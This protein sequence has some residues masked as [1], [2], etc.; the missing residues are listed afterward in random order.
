MAEGKFLVADVISKLKN[1]HATVVN[2]F[3]TK[4]MER[5]KTLKKKK[6][7]LNTTMTIN[8]EIIG[9]FT[10]INRYNNVKWIPAESSTQAQVSP[11]KSS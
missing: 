2:K 6:Q 10:A 8:Y 3:E 1:P 9:M 7:T 4:I 5:E 11:R